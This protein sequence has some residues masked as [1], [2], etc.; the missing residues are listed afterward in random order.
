[1]IRLIIVILFSVAGCASKFCPRT[2]EVRYLPQAKISVDGSL[3]EPVWEKTYVE[4]GFSFP[5]ESGTAPI[6]EFRSLCDDEF[7]YFSFCA[8]D[9]DV[10]FEKTFDTESTVD[11]EDRVEIF[12]ARDDKLKEYFCLEIDPL[13]R[14]H[15]YAASYYRKFDSSWDCP[16]I[17]TAASLTEYGYVVECSVPLKVFESLSLPSLSSGD[18]LKVGLFRAEL[19]RRQNSKPQAHWISW[20]DPKTKKPD[21]HLPNAFGCLRRT[22]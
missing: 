5:W 19:I 7:F 13:G 21:F 15:D 8:Y 10:V 6:T 18:V 14:L 11:G 17:C 2:Y 16:G 20:I 12:L 22:E 4:K 1:M 3:N 9:K